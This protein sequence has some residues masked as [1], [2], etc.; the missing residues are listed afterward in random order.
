MLLPVRPRPP[1]GNKDSRDG[2]VVAHKVVCPGAS[3]REDGSR[4]LGWVGWVYMRVQ[5]GVF[6]VSSLIE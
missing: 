2:W 5:L 3:S 1:L 6:F 4:T